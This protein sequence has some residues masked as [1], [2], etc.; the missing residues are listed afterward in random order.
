MPTPPARPTSTPS[1]RAR[2]AELA[3]LRSLSLGG[4]GG[5]ATD[6]NVAAIV[7]AMGPHL[8][9]LGMGSS[10][11]GNGVRL[12]AA[13]AA[14]IAA[15][16]PALVDLRLESATQLGDAE[17]E[18]LLRALRLRSLALTGHDRTHGRLTDAGLR[19]LREPEFAPRLEKLYITDQGVNVKE[20]LQV[21]RRRARGGLEIQAGDTDSDSAAAGMVRGMMGCEYGDGIYGNMDNSRWL[22]AA[23]KEHRIK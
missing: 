3:K 22:A 9:N 15:G 7:A 2:R 18:R 19:L 20:V 13:S 23:L 6:P 14:A 16:C 1:S 4:D 12:T 21:L 5:L 11:S 10:D 17:F 8:R